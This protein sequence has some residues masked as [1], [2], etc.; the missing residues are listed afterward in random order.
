MGGIAFL[1]QGDFSVMPDLPKMYQHCKLTEDADLNLM[2]FVTDHLL[3]INGS[4]D[5]H[6]FGDAQKR[7]SSTPF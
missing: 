6:D 5:K 3:D 7:H 1:P 4:F 2:D